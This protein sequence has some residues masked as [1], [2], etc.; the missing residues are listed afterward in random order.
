ML[1]TPEVTVDVS[2]GQDCKAEFQGL[3]YVE[4]AYNMSGVI[5]LSAQDTWNS[6]TII[7]SV[8]SF[9]ETNQGYRRFK[10]SVN[11]PLY[12][13]STKNGQ[14]FITG[15]C[16]VY[17]PTEMY[18]NCE[19]SEGVEGKINIAQFHK[20]KLISP[21]KY[22]NVDPGKTT[23][24]RIFVA[25]MGNGNETFHVRITNLK[26][27]KK[28]GLDLTISPTTFELNEL[29]E[30]VVKLVATTPEGYPTHEIYNIRVE[31][32]NNK[33]FTEGGG[34]IVETY[35]IRNGASYYYQFQV[36]CISLVIILAVLFITTIYYA[37]RKQKKR[38]YVKN[39]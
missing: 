5:R 28:T 18:C 3:V 39:W 31:V 25:N 27:L 21:S 14:L 16:E 8:F 37:R 11:V 36:F 6:A 22:T 33:T 9:S 24:F 34:F 13:S 15:R 29:E 19:P 1:E 30:K 32:T 26:E 12:T 20:F 2:P 23:N 17:R 4:C 10:V 35:K 7:P 38:K